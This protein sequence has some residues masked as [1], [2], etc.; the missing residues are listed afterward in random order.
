M[1][2]NNDCRTGTTVSAGTAPRSTGSPPTREEVVSLTHRLLNFFPEKPGVPTDVNAAAVISI[3]LRFPID[4]VERCCDPFTGLASMQNTTPT[5]Y[6]VRKFCDTLM[7]PRQ[8]AR[9]RRVSEDMQLAE[10]QQ[11]ERLRSEQR[12]TIEEIEDE[13]AARG[14]FMCGWIE[15][16]RRELGTDGKPH[17]ET[18]ETVRAKAGLS[19]EAWDALPDSKSKGGADHGK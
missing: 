10:R 6:D 8:V 18:P 4:I 19:Q 17:G 7:L 9:S 14:I 3:F 16:H 5:P 12:P 11:I 1:A 15:R 13:M 2:V